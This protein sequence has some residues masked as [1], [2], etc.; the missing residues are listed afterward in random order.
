MISQRSDLTFKHNLKQ[1]RHGWLRLTPAYSIKIVQNVLASIGKPEFVLDPF[2]GTGTTGLVCAE[3]GIKSDLV[4]INP[5]LVWLAAAKIAHYHADELDAAN[6]LARDVASKV[7]QNMTV[8]DLWIPPLNY[9]DR[10]WLPER[11]IVLA[12]LFD[13]LKNICG[14]TAAVKLCLIAFCKVVINW[15]NAAFNH[16]SMS[17]KKHHQ[18]FLPEERDMIINDFITQV[19]QIAASAK[20]PVLSKVTIHQGDSRCLDRLLSRTYDCVI[21][22]PP[23]PNRMSYIREVRPYMYWLGFLKSARE[24]GELD[25]QAIGG[26]WGIATSRLR[27]WQPGN[28]KIPH[29]GFENTIEQI[30]VQSPILGNYVHKYFRDIATHIDRLSRVLAAGAKIYYIVGNSKFYDTL[31]PVEQ[32]Y[33][34]LLREYGFSNVSSAVLRKRNSKKELYEFAVSADWLG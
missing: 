15:S 18:R 28:M 10:W 11:L 27:W 31:V 2:S 32:I 12:N 14:E 7:C 1:G 17:F 29:E 25:W 20:L 23:Y 8:D 26:T 5:F 30:S 21:T 4:E 6:A 3:L 24:A 34:S 33:M 19:Q 16:Q 22:S 13:R 9:I